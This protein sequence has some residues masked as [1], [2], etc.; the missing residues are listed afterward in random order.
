MDIA[1][2]FFLG[3][4]HLPAVMMNKRIPWPALQLH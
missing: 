4:A 3:L 2:N 1:F